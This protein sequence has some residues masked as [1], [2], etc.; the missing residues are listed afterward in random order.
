MSVNWTCAD[1]TGD[2][3]QYRFAIASRGKVA[4]AE[5][6]GNQLIVGDPAKVHELYRLGSWVVEASGA[7]TNR[8]TLVLG[9]AT[10]SPSS[11]ELAFEEDTVSEVEASARCVQI[12]TRTFHDVT[13]I[14]VQEGGNSL[15]IE[16][17]ESDEP[18]APQPTQPAQPEPA[19]APEPE[20]DLDVQLA[21]QLEQ[22]RAARTA[23]E[24]QVSMLQEQLSSERQRFATL[25]GV[26]AGR[27]EEAVANARASRDTLSAELAASLDAIEAANR[28]AEDLGRQNAEAQTRVQTLEQQLAELRAQREELEQLEEAHTLDCDQARADMEELRARYGAN[29]GTAQLMQTDPFLKGNSVK[30]TLEKVTKELQSIERRIGMIIT[31]RESFL[32]DVQLSLADG[33]GSLPL[34]RDLERGY[35]GDDGESEEADSQA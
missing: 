15:R 26:A 1:E 20:V 23:A 13:S 16:C 3:R 18:P 4:L 24:Q 25:Q 11:I 2:V 31:Y 14:V 30:K 33:D 19:P 34:S 22:E 35:D 12:S 6:G 21:A 10:A 17:S 28:E 29:E 32:R 5:G 27:L 8:L 9:P 7:G